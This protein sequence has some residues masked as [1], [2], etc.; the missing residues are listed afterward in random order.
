MV[1]ETSGGG[2]AGAGA[3]AEAA[4]VRLLGGGHAEL[5][6]AMVAVAALRTPANTDHEVVVEVGGRNLP[7][8]PLVETALGRRPA[9]THSAEE[10]LHAL[11]FTM[12]VRRR[13]DKVSGRPVVLD[14]AARKSSS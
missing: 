4:R 1:A 5:T 9:N 13:Y 2:G 11:G 3:E 6:L 7:V 8:L 14:R 10:A 12:Y